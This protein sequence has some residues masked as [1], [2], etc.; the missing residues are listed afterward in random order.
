MN[1]SVDGPDRNEALAEQRMRQAGRGEH[2]EQV[3]L[4]DSELHVLSLRRYHPSLER[5]DPLLREQ[6]FLRLVME[7][8]APIHPA[9]EIRRDGHVRGRGHDPVGERPAGAGDRVEGAAERLLGRSGGS[10][11]RRHR[12][13]LRYRNRRRTGTP[14]HP[15]IERNPGEKSPHVRLR[16][17]Q[18]RERLPLLSL[19]HPVR[20]AHRLD[21][22]RAQQS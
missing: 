22:L 21:I 12:L 14:G 15:L 3:V 8:A 13:R 17:I 4:R 10:A 20:S 2:Q 1:G 16:D 18:P 11:P 19:R 5:S 7:E 6:V 9:A